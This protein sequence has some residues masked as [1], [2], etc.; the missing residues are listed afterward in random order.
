MKITE[1]LFASTDVLKQKKRKEI[2]AWFW[3]MRVVQV[4]LAYILPIYFTIDTYY[5][6]VGEDY[7]IAPIAYLVVGII[8]LLFYSNM[9]QR[10]KDWETNKRLKYTMLTAVK[11]VPIVAIIF[12]LG[13]IDM[14]TTIFMGLMEKIIISY[15]G[16]LTLDFWTEPLRTEMRVRDKIRMNS[17]LNRIID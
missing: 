16:S 11:L 7:A 10:L 1:A 8:L 5:G 12:V 2:R 13:V 17:E 3:P 4:M 6:G 9:K 15:I 14:N